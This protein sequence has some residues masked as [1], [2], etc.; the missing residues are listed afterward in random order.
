M[1][2]DSVCSEYAIAQADLNLRSTHMPEGTSSD[3]AANS[4]SFLLIIFKRIIKLMHVWCVVCDGS[5]P[6]VSNK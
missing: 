5:L 4:G 6:P 3:V 2:E 1:C